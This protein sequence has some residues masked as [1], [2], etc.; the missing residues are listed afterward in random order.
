[1]TPLL[2]PPFILQIKIKNLLINYAQTS[3]KNNT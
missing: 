3:Y 2:S 1:M